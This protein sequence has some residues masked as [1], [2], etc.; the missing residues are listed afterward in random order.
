MSKRLIDIIQ[1][2]VYKYLD[3][4]F[5]SNR[6]IVNVDSDNCLNFMSIVANRDINCNIFE[7]VLRLY[8]IITNSI[9]VNINNIF[10][11]K[12]DASILLYTDRYRCCTRCEVGCSDELNLDYSYSIYPYNHRGLRR[13]T[14]AIRRDNK[15]HTIPYD[16]LCRI[17]LIVNNKVIECPDYDCFKYISFYNLYPH[18]C[19]VKE[20][21]TDRYRF[22]NCEYD[23]ITNKGINFMCVSN[24][25][26]DRESLEYLYSG[27]HNFHNAETFD[28]Y[29]TLL[30]DTRYT[31]SSINDIMS[32]YNLVH[33][34]EHT[35]S[36]T[37]FDLINFETPILNFLN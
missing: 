33:I 37:L 9:N 5:K 34:E 31:Y 17:P 25:F 27:C 30:R 12:Y 24:E 16:L 8:D 10:K 26:T 36:N 35:D 7:E 13:Y 2:D 3:N 21:K 22:Y 29:K 23:S 32:E 6:F 18:F 19:A 14:M 28:Y 15:T 4:R 11:D 1:D 20:N